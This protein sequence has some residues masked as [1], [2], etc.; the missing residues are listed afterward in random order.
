VVRH[1]DWGS[2]TAIAGLLG[3]PAPSERPEA[4][5]WLGAHPSGPAE[6]YVEGRWERLDHLLERASEPLLGSSPLAGFERRLPF[7]LKLLAVERPL[8]LQAHP[9]PVQARAGFLREQERGEAGL[10][11]Y[12]DPHAKPEL[13]CALTP[14]LAMCGLR[15]AAEVR[16][17]LAPCGLATLL[18]GD[19]DD[20]CALRE[21]LRAW[22]AAEPAAR[23][24][25]LQRALRHAERTAATDPDSAT[26][27]ALAAEHPEDPGVLA[28]WFLHRIE[29]APGEA[30]FLPPGELHCYLAGTAVE[31]MA[32]SDNVVRAGL[33]GKTVDVAELLR[34]V[35][36]AS[37]RPPVL[38]PEP[39]RPGEG[40]WTTPAEEFELSL[41]TPAEGA[42]VA[43]PVRSGIE[44]LWCAEGTVR[45]ESAAHAGV[46]LARGESCLVPAATGAYR[47]SGVGRSFRAA[48]PE[49][50]RA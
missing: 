27:L 21:F 4:E 36:T 34:I 49:P 44:I 14:F 45:V 17:R 12:A 19:P 5:L 31:I 47:V 3:R 42:P 37:R 1:Y 16:E 41:L 39:R 2:R 15:P 33:T 25:P 35:R 30:I 32:S 40:V 38:R 46:E 24:G 11:L 9:D 13:V 43:L 18:P 8:S 22:L 7:L 6:A 48:L 50:A 28:P 29:L 23:R 20:P 10:R 26:I